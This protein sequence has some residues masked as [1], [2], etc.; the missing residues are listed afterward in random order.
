MLSQDVALIEAEA[1]ANYWA[2]NRDL[3]LDSPWIML[4]FHAGAEK[5]VVLK[6]Y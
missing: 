3:D 5:I 6:Q 2:Y 4:S 1:F